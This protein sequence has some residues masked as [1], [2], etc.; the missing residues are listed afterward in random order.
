M[1]HLFSHHRL[2]AITPSLHGNKML[3][4]S[5]VYLPSSS[6][7]SIA[8][9]PTVTQQEPE[10]LYFWDTNTQPQQRQPVVVE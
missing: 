6:S 1:A 9:C 3:L 2:L 5:N 8:R 4:T 7:P 10:H